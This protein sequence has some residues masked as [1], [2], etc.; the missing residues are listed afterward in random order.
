MRFLTIILTK[1]D[2]FLMKRKKSHANS[3]LDYSFYIILCYI[4]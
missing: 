2:I 3:L 4:N 1:T